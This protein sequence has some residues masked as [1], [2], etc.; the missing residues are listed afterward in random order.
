VSAAFDYLPEFSM[1]LENWQAGLVPIDNPEGL[2]EPAGGY[3]FVSFRM[4][5]PG[6]IGFFRV[7][8]ST[9]GG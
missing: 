5:D 7:N 8:I 3:R 9:R 4:P 1:G 6:K 2:P